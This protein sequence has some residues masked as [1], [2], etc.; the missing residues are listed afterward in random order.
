MI[1]SSKEYTYVQINDKYCKNHKLH[2]NS[3]LLTVIFATFNTNSILCL[4]QV[5]FAPV[6]V[7]EKA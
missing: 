7:I 2:I 4:T 5:D 3:I 1:I 6:L